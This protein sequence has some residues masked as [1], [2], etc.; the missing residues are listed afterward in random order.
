MTSLSFAVAMVNGTKT[1]VI[2]FL[3]QIVLAQAWVPIK[4]IYVALNGVS[5][6]LSVAA[7]T[8]F[9]FPAVLR[10]IKKIGTVHRMILAIVSIIVIDF[11]LSFSVDLF[12]GNHDFTI[13]ATYVFPLHRTEDFI[14][15]CIIGAL[16]LKIENSCA[17]KAFLY[18]TLEGLAIAGVLF[19][20]QLSMNGVFPIWAKYQLAFIIPA[21][22]F[23]FIFALN[24]GFLSRIMTNKAVF[25]ISSISGYAFLIHQKIIQWGLKAMSLL[26]IQIGRGYQFLILAIITVLLSATINTVYKQ[27]A[28]SKVKMTH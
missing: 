2:A 6:Y 21:A 14:I 16:Y 23:V 8:Y 15:G 28:T 26:N 24:K 1:E 11:I 27:Y 17:N 22:F 18:T 19:V 7:F 12:I 25:F 3:F 10:L 9:V 20:E 4:A 5:W 13:W